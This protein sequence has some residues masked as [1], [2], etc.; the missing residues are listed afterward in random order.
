[1][2]YEKYKG[3]YWKTKKSR[4]KIFLFTFFQIFSF[5]LVIRF[6]SKLLQY[7]YTE[8]VSA[9]PPS[10]F[11]AFIFSTGFSNPCFLVSFKSFKFLAVKESLSILFKMFS[12]FKFSFR[13]PC[14]SCRSIF[15]K[16]NSCLN[17]NIFFKMTTTEN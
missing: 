5:Q 8:N 11:H 7:H 1:M 4:A 9:N 12:R 3:K 15:L 14:W 6:I 2:L 10:F 13:Y 17:D 16:T